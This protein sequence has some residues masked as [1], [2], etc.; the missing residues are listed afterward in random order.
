MTWN[1]INLYQY[2]QIIEAN[3]IEYPIDRIDRLIAIVNNWTANQVN[4]LNV[5]KYN[6]EVK[7]LAFLD[8]EP[9]GQPV[10]YID[11]NGKRY[12]CIYDV[13]KM[14]S[15]RYIESKVFQ[16]DL[17]PN[18][19][20]LAASMVIPMKKTIWGWKEVS[21]DSIMHPVYSEDMLEA[22]FK[23]IYHSIVFFYHVYRI[24][25][26]V[27]KGYLKI[28]LQM[29]GVNQSEKALADLLNIMD[30]SIAPHK[31]QNTIVSRLTKH[32]NY[33]P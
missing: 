30:G 7:R 6:A 11:V 31:L 2:Q 26:E 32:I 17:I 8:T 16:T 10:K 14:P 22:K 19:H 9:D 29:Q 5:E 15:A 4:D 18:L 23:D 20:K 28:Q 21:Y 1:D 13:R 25:I 12:K 27:S 3:K 24:W 33:Q